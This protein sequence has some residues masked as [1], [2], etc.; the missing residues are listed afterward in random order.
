[1][2]AYL[3]KTFVA[4][5]LGLLLFSCTSPTTTAPEAQEQIVGLV[6]DVLTKEE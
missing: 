5:A 6:E 4:A 2:N 3:N 1:M